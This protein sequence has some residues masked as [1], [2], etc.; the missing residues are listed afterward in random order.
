MK[1]QTFEIVAAVNDQVI[2]EQHLLRSPLVSKGGVTVF[3]EHGFASAGAAYNAGLAKTT[4]G[5]V[6]FVHQD[7]YLPAGWDTRLKRAIESLDAA[8]ER[9]GVLGVWGIRNDGR[10]AGHVW[11]TGG[12]MEHFRPANSENGIDEVESIDEIVIVLNKRAGLKFDEKLPGFHLYATDIALE[13]QR[14]G[15]KT[16]AFQGPVVH[17]SRSHPRPVNADYARGYRYMRRKWAHRLPVRTSVIPITRTGWPLIR[18]L[19]RQELSLLRHGW[20]PARPRVDPDKIAARLG[21]EAPTTQSG[22]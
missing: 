14:R 9:W 10:F 13:A 15:L 18:H 21:Y 20:P 19:L 6:A 7:V 12:N 1:T 4:G 5:V 2:F 17:N 16:F 22:G 3:A 8:A 11:C